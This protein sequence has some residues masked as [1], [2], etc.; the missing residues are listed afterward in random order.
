LG[1]V[2]GGIGG[3]VLRAAVPQQVHRNRFKGQTLDRGLTSKIVAAPIFD[4]YKKR[5]ILIY[6]GFFVS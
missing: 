3:P 2:Q 5:S 4:C 6:I 1:R